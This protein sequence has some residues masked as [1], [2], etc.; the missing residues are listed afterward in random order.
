M[1][2][3]HLLTD[4]PGSA[5]AESV[6]EW[7]SR[8]SPMASRFEAPLEVA[9]AGGFAADRLGFAFAAGYHAALRA[10]VPELP[11]DHLVALC[12]TE[13]GGAH[14]RAI[15]TAL[16]GYGESS[17]LSGDKRWSTLAPA[18]HELLVLASL[19]QDAAGKEQLRLVRVRADAA[20]VRIT[21]MPAPPFTPEIPHAEIELRA[22]RVSPEDVLA[23]DGWERYVKP[24]RTLEDLH[25]H[26]ALLGYLIGVARRSGWPPPEIE[27]LL[28][29]VVT[30][31]ALAAEPA[32][33]PETHV[34]LAGLLE[35]TA[36]TVAETAELWAGVEPD[37]RARWERDRAL[38]GVAAS[39]RA[40]RTARAWERLSAG[41]GVE[42]AGRRS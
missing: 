13:E 34:A 41:S 20:G 28:A 11:A 17:S 27:R 32:G 12:A 4:Q 7:W 33:A 36:R 8:W 29:L 15:R 42:I 16:S 9:V 6:T 19:G 39:A 30:T 14:P 40:A 37:E 5:R 23:G 2:L 35:A 31:R 24:F 21:A 22:V 18:A 1:L 25:V 26:G 3:T 10:L 38:L